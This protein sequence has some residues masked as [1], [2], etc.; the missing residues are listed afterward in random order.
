MKIAT[1]EGPNVISNICQTRGKTE[2]TFNVCLS[3]I[4]F[5]ARREW[6]DYLNNHTVDGFYYKSNE[7][8]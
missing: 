5:Y 7:Y 2:R 4:N 8:L 3:S 6:T 1:D